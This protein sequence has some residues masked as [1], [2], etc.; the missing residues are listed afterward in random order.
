ME[1]KDEIKERFSSPSVLTPETTVLN[2]PVYLWDEIFTG[3]LRRKLLE[4]KELTE[5]DPTSEK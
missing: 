3:Q 4:F 5:G 1:R 2:I